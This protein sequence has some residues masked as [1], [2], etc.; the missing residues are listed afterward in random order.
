MLD[1]FISQFLF[2]FLKFFIVCQGSVFDHFF[3]YGCR[4]DMLRVPLTRSVVGLNFLPDFTKELLVLSF[5]TS[6]KRTSV[7]LY[8]GACSSPFLYVFAVCPHLTELQV[9][10][11]VSHASRFV[12]LYLTASLLF[13]P[14]S[15]CS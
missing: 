12:N 6:L 1:E 9:I 14:S 5:I 2:L 4:G 3:F 15:E 13:G 8:F 11:A 7:F 10:M